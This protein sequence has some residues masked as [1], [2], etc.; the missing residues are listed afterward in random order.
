MM[1]FL[2]RATCVSCR[3]YDS[4]TCLCHSRLVY[5]CLY[6]CVHMSGLLSLLWD[7]GICLKAELFSLG[8]LKSGRL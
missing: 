4:L 2:K 6:L 3:E 7:G 1:P 8:C 5:V